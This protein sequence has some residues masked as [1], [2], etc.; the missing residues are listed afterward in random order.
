MR[1]ISW[2]F[3]VFFRVLKIF[4]FL[5]SPTPFL[6]PQVSRIFHRLSEPPPHS[7]L[8]VG[9]GPSNLPTPLAFAPSQFSYSL[10]Q[11]PRSFK[12]FFI[13]SFLLE[14]D[15]C[16]RLF[17]CDYHFLFFVPPPNRS[18]LSWLGFFF[19]SPSQVCR[20]LAH[21]TFIKFFFCFFWGPRLGPR[22]RFPP[23]NYAPGPL[24]LLF[25]TAPSV[26]PFFFRA[27]FFC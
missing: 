14:V 4:L 19:F 20:S 16:L 18:F 2:V 5:R 10:T 24:F 1:S 3:L 12:L 17:S 15:F 8:V 22:M 7:P 6:P 27:L 25:S 26:S 21:S 23:P 9:G 11:F 13:S